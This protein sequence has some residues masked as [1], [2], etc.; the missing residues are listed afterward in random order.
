[1]CKGS[2]R[3]GVYG[4]NKVS[5][6][7]QSHD[8]QLSPPGTIPIPKELLVPGK[9]EGNNVWLKISYNTPISYCLHDLGEVQ[10][11]KKDKQWNKKGQ[12]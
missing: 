8:G 7:L 4:Y 5:L 12:L 1:M 11:E 10:G 2:G 9:W 3:V 6:A